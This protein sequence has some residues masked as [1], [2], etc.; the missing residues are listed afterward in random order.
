MK[1]CIEVVSETQTLHLQVKCCLMRNSPENRIQHNQVTELE[2][3]KKGH[4]R[5]CLANKEEVDEVKSEKKARGI[6][7]RGAKQEEKEGE[8]RTTNIKNGERVCA[9]GRQT[10]RI[11]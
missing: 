11:E 9:A 7:R 6:R 3:T 5:M 2:E 1:C 8:K 4:G 10:N